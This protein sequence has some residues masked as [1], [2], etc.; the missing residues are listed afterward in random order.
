MQHRAYN[1][2]VRNYN[3][4]CKWMSFIDL[5]EFVVPKVN[6]TIPEFLEAYENY[7]QVLMFW[8]MYG[9]SNHKDRP[10]GLVIENYTCHAEKTDDHT[11]QI[12]NPRRVIYADVHY[13]FVVGEIT[14]ENFKKHYSNV[15]SLASSEKI[16]V[17]HYFI[18]SYEDFRNKYSKG[19][20][21]N[22]GFG[23]LDK[24]FQE[25]DVNDVCDDLMNKYVKELKK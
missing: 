4:E 25:N 24:C 16:Q 14:D 5:D 21:D 22:R 7:S 13:S 6:K 15:H 9:S 8:M 1:D 23:D 17:N 12:V 20:T 11:K 3:N 18:K 2:A 10:Q 19:R